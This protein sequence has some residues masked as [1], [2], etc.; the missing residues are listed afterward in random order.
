MRSVALVAAVLLA[1]CGE[2]SVDLDVPDRP[3]GAQV[4]DEVG[5]LDGTDAADRLADFADD[6]LDAIAV[7]YE[8]DQANAGEARRA[9]QQVLDEWD[10]DIALVAVAQPGDFE[11]TDADRSRFF[12]LESTDTFALPRGLRERVVEDVVPPLAADNEWPD[13]FE[14]AIDALDDELTG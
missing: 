10:A 12:G 1:A 3:A 11:S 14:A 7:V 6:D 4:L 9:G 8:T 13:A 5:L 2:P